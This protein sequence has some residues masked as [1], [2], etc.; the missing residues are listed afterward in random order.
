MPETPIVL[1]VEP[2]PGD[3]SDDLEELAV[4]LRPHATI[5]APGDGPPLKYDAVALIAALGSAGVIT[6]VVKIVQAYLQRNRG[7]KATLEFDGRKVR[8]DGYSGAE[9]ERILHELQS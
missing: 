4:Q 9:I 1:R 3:D 8:L 2:G 7:R 6:A 5:V